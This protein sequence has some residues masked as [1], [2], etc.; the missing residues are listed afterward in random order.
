MSSP[1]IVTESRRLAC[2]RCG[3]AFECGS[4][5]G[6]CWCAEE[7][8]QLPMPSEGSAE[9]CLC[10]AC[11]RKAAGIVTPPPPHGESAR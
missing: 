6:K 10:Q 11:L 5:A 2:A 7:D 4:T 9:D 3:A 1:A 8:F